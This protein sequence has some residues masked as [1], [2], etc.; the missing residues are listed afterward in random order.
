VSIK[1]LILSYALT[2]GMLHIA[3]H[4]ICL[5]ESVTEYFKR[6]QKRK[7]HTACIVLVVPT[8][9]CE[10]E[11]CSLIK[12]SEN[13]RQSTVRKLQRNLIVCTARFTEI[14]TLHRIQDGRLSKPFWVSTY[15]LEDIMIHLL[16]N[17]L[18]AK[19]ICKTMLGKPKKMNKTD[20]TIYNLRIF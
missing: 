19:H 10:S 14:V 13:E 7:Q 16:N 20:L 9:L 2:I 8:L 11:T 18:K 3:I 1:H 17:D 6:Q 5:C 15:K 4:I 12:R